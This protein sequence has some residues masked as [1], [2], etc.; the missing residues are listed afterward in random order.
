MTTNGLLLDK[1]LDDLVNKNFKILVSLDGDFDASVYRVGEDGRDLYDKIINN[2]DLY[3]NKYPLH[4]ERNVDFNVV[5]HRK[6]DI[7]SVFSFIKKKYGKTPRFSPLSTRNVKESQK[8]T[9]KTMYR[10]MPD[11]L[12]EGKDLDAITENLHPYTS[13]FMEM[14]KFANA[15]LDI[16][17]QT[18]ND[19]FVNTG[20]N[21]IVYTP[22]GTCWPFSR[23]FF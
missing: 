5:I 15:L 17:Y 4:F 2:L 20:L 16:Q 6:N 9:F 1:Y 12:I 21:D 13:G 22:S 8:E 23:K 14:V 11:D 10:K 3:K 18:Y 19:L 7:Q